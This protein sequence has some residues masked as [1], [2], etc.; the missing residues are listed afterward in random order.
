MYTTREPNKLDETLG[1]IKSRIMGKYGQGVLPPG[2]PAGFDLQ[3]LL[4]VMPFILKGVFFRKSKP[5]PFFINGESFATP[6][7]LTLQE[8]NAARTA[9][10]VLNVR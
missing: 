10:K 8:R 9:A 4:T 5:S 7:I 6:K 1:P 3:A 2:T